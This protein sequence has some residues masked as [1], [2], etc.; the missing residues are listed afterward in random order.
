VAQLL[1]LIVEV[2]S[3]HGSINN[4]Y[5]SWWC[6]LDKRYQVFVSSTYDDLREERQEVIQALLE[7][8]CILSG[9][10]L[11]PAANDDQWTL[12][13]RVIDDCDYYLVIIGG[14]YGSTSKSGKSYTQMEYEYA[15]SKD[16]P[17]IAFL[18]K[19]PNAIPSGK[20]DKDEQGKKK[21]DEFREIAK[22]KLVRF[23]SSPQELGSVVSR[24]IVK[25]IK[26]NPAVGWAKA[27]E[28]VEEMA[29]PEL[30]KLRKQ[31]DDLHNRLEES[32]DRGPQGTE[33]FAQGEENY[34]LLFNTRFNNE[35]DMPFTWDVPRQISWN[36]IFR[37]ISPLMIDR[38]SADQLSSTLATYCQEEIIKAIKQDTRKATR[39][40]INLAVESLRTI[41][42][43]LRALGLIARDNRQ[44]SVRDTA[45][46]WT[47]TPYGDNVMTRLRAILKSSDT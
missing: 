3:D 21:L 22:Q 31:I 9:M 27:N 32:R 33:M 38:G 46:Y 2:A 25:L 45:T 26:S 28:L 16:K 34:E 47:L 30:L 29:A 4:Q 35:K 19:N 39:I 17:V 40:R 42:I 13:K 8:D 10:E 15:I 12:I 37:V 18:H 6:L 23:W 14:R 7:L 43:Q 11:F 20:T 36:D 44:K 41:I 5:S 24:S 1:R